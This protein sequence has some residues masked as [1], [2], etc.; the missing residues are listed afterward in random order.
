MTRIR[1]YACAAVLLALAACSAGNS[2]DGGDLAK[3]VEE[4]LESANEGSTFDLTC[5]DAEDISKGK[6]VDCSGDMV[7]TASD[8]SQ[9]VDVRVTFDDDDGHFTAEVQNG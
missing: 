9:P 8:E 5:S 7:D 2:I 3:S 6:I 1:G 4:S